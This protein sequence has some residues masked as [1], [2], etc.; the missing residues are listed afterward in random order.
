MHTE[1][2]GI[3]KE[4]YLK[5]T[6]NNPVRRCRADASEVMTM[7]D[8]RCPE[9]ELRWDERIEKWDD[10]SPLKQGNETVQANNSTIRIMP[11]SGRVHRGKLQ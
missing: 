3:W 10:N 5:Y 2:K 11:E 6:L 7:F 9:S 4:L 8:V 1:K